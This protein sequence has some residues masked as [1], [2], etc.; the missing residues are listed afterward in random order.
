MQSFFQP[1]PVGTAVVLIGKD[2]FVKSR[3]ADLDLAE[4]FATIDR[5][6]MRRREM[7]LQDEGAP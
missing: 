3:S 7:R 4:T 5:M 6:P 2:G 1:P